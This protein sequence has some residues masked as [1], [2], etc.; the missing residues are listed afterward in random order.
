[1]ATLQDLERRILELEK[2][3]K[4]R[5]VQQITFPLDDKSREVLNKYFLS[6]I[7]NLDFTQS[8]GAEFRQILVKQDGRVN[9]LSAYMSLSRYTVNTSSNVITIGPD[10][11]NAGKMQ[12]AD[13]AQVVILS[14][15]G[16]PAP[17]TESGT[18]YVVNAASD[19]FS[20]QLSLTLG[21]AAI[22]ITTTGTG[23]Q[24]L[25]QFS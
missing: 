2:S 23:D 10:V 20:F 24:Y 13:D 7:G 9:L 16:P 17:L 5:K 4:Q 12:F 15:G 14:T 22:N 3:E 1:M 18:Y 25:Y 6:Y 11:V 21:G 19:G 8:T